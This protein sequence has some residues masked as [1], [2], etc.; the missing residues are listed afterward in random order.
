MVGSSNL[1]NE[2]IFVSLPTA[3]HRTTIVVAG[4][5]TDVESK[6]PNATA[7]VHRARM[8]TP[9]LALPKN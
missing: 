5:V 8:A 9:R 3:T 1:P 6:L 2:A 4:R 7:V